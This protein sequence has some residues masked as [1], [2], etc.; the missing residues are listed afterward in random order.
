MYNIGCRECEF[1]NVHSMQKDDWI[2]SCKRLDHKHYQFVTPIFKDYD[3][4]SAICSDFQPSKRNVYMRRL[5]HDRYIRF[6][7]PK[8]NATVRLVIDGDQ[9]VHYYV[10]HIDFF[11]NEFINPDG[12]LKW[13]YKMYQKR[14]KWSALGYVLVLEYPDGRFR[15]NGCSEYFNSLDGLLKKE[16]EIYL[17]CK[18]HE[19][20]EWEEHKKRVEY[21][22][23][24]KA[25]I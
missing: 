20:K 2:S 6:F 14:T 9:S 11:N 21:L 23:N 17:E 3:Y 8:E 25:G 24:N 5:W 16:K 7:I 12:S 13:I 22:N 19:Q 4:A 10:R 15:K 18:E 1:H